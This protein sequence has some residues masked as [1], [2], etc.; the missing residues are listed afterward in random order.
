MSDM[1]LK[2]ED[3]TKSYMLGKRQVPALTNLN[4]EVKKGEFVC[5]VGAA[6][7]CSEDAWTGY[8]DAADD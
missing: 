8:V 4:V 2:I 6:W 7:V 3:L 1:A 5:F